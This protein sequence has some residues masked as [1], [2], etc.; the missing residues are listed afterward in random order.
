[1][2]RVPMPLLILWAML[3]SVIIVVGIGFA[4]GVAGIVVPEGEDAISNV[5]WALAG[6]LIFAP[7]LLLLTRLIG[8][9]R[10]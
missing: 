6:V 9:L 8:R 2:K 3:S 4:G 1:L 7:F 10:K 5:A